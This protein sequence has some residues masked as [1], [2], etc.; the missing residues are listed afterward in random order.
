[1]Y[2]HKSVY[3]ILPYFYMAVG[4]AIYVAGSLFPSVA[5]FELLDN[6][7][8]YSS[9]ALLYAAGAFVWVARSAY[10]RK[11]SKH[12]VTNRKGLLQFPERIYEYLPF[13]YIAM[14][15]V[16]VSQVAGLYG[17]IP[18]FV[19]CLAGVLVLMIRAIYRNYD[20]PSTGS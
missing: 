1:M 9:D 2:I 19:L 17:S 5:F 11:N 12:Q 3:E 4:V 7:L 14:G 16:L 8:V 6:P 18:G 10:R 15:L 13:I 20:V